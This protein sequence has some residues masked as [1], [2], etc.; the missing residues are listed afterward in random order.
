[1]KSTLAPNCKQALQQDASSKGKSYLEACL[2]L[3]NRKGERT[4]TFISN[5]SR[6]KAVSL[7]QSSVKDI[8][9][10]EENLTVKISISADDSVEIH[11]LFYPMPEKAEF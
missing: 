2:S 7:L 8:L 1:M 3:P 5:V 10:K 11:I 9:R 6:C 4:V